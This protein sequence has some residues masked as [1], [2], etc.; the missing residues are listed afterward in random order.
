MSHLTCT[1]E[2]SKHTNKRIYSIMK[3]ARLHLVKRI[4]PRTWYDIFVIEVLT[5]YNHKLCR[6]CYHRCLA[7]LRKLVMV[8]ID[9]DTYPREN[10]LVIRTQW[11]SGEKRTERRVSSSF[12][13][14]REQTLVK[15][16]QSMIYANIRINNVQ[17]LKNSSLWNL[18]YFRRSSNLSLNLAS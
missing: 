5:E 12:H 6:I 15:D 10:C 16:S 13:H 2:I 18:I 14:N 9:D 4:E 7:K 3:N 11:W 1:L 8:I 17:D